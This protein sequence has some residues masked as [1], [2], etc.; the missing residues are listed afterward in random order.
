MN[1][2]SKSVSMKGPLGLQIHLV[3]I[4]QVPDGMILK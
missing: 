4:S 1:S 3:G 2:C